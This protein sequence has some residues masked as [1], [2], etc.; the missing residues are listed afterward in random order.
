[1]ATAHKRKI[2]F[3]KIEDTAK[4]F[5]HGLISGAHARVGHMDENELNG[6]VDKAFDFAQ[7][8]HE[9]A[10]DKEDAQ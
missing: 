4:Q 5:L 9:K 1:M 2:D 7:A 6:L 3:K 8:F 10:A